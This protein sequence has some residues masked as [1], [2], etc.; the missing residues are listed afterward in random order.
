MA[1][2]GYRDLIYLDITARNDWSSTLPSENR[3]YFYPSA[4][5]SLMI[6]NMVDLGSKVN[7]LKVRGGIAQ[8]GNDTSPYS[9]YATY[10]DAGQWVML[11]GSENREVY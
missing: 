1:N 4:S 9:L 3:S 8:V 5:L 7:L 2:M 6:N 11:S 10:Y